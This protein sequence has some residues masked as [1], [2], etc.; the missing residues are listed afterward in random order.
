MS[1][2]TTWHH[3]SKTSP[4]STRQ[5]RSVPLVFRQP[6]TDGNAEEF[7]LQVTG[8]RQHEQINAHPMECT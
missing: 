7:L 2:W 5:F 4:A 1:H 3:L 6:Q 8:D